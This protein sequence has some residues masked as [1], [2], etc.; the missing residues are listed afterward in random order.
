MNRMVRP[1]TSS[2]K[3]CSSCLMLFEGG[4]H[5]ETRRGWGA[6]ISGS[7]AAGWGRE[8]DRVGA[9]SP[10]LIPRPLGGSGTRRDGGETNPISPESRGRRSNPAPL[11][12]TPPPPADL[13]ALCV[14]RGSKTVLHPADAQSSSTSSRFSR[15]LRFKSRSA[16][17]A[18][19]AVQMLFRNP[20]HGKSGIRRGSAFQ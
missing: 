18:D 20:L 15:S 9:H 10:G 16:L 7:E 3:S 19:F 2:C 5:A 6:A 8:R 1:P 17:F 4:T 14:L 11:P 12:R 13:C